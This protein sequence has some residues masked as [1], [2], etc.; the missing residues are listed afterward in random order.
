MTEQYID[1]KYITHESGLP[2]RV[3]PYLRREI[4]SGNPS[5]QTQISMMRHNSHVGIRNEEDTLPL[6]MQENIR[7]R[8][9]A[10]TASRKLVTIAEILGAKRYI[11]VVHGSL[12]KGL[13]RHPSD[14][15]RSDIDIDLVVDNMIIPKETKQQIREAIYQKTDQFGARVDTYVWTMNQVRANVG[16]YARYYLSSGAYPIADENSMWE[17]IGWMGIK[18]QQFTELNDSKVRSKLRKVLPLIAEG[19]IDEALQ[20]IILG[21][22]IGDNTYDYLAREVL[23]EDEICA[24][25]AKA[26]KLCLLLEQ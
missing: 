22:R 20:N 4:A 11:T 26:R 23:L 10:R 8:R 18:G 1:G 5:A 17:E 7:L 12:S 21:T 19:K 15:D 16:L 3:P 6:N 14:T 9:I 2:L 13:V 25:Q 24:V